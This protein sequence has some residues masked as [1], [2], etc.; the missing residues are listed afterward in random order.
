MGLGDLYW[1]GAWAPH[2][3]VSGWGGEVSSGVRDVCVNVGV[4]MW[5]GAEG[6]GGGPGA[7][8]KRR[9]LRSTW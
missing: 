5:G 4:Q 1:G 3:T 7:P 8:Q 6:W 9:C 2:G